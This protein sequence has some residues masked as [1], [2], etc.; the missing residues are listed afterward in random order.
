MP[1]PPQRERL[2]LPP[3]ADESDDDSSNRPR[4]RFQSSDEDGDDPRNTTTPQRKRRRPERV[5]RHRLHSQ[6]Q[7]SN[8]SLTG[9]NAAESTM[10]DRESAQ[11]EDENGDLLLPEPQDHESGDPSATTAVHFQHFVEA[12]LLEDCGFYQ[13]SNSL[14]VV[15]GWDPKKCEPTVSLISVS[16]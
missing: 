12:V 7:A 2:T 10:Q 6:A 13:L 16:C 11:S 1:S 3:I 9:N 8:R 4:F 5:S 15:N 14:F